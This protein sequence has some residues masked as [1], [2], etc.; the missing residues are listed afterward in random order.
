MAELALKPDRERLMAHITEF[1]RRVKLSGT[2]E[3]LESFRY[4]QAQ[5]DSYGYRTQ[6]LSHD[7]YISLPGAAK[8][9]ID[10]KSLRC[11]THSMSVPTSAAG[12][13]GVLV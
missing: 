5:M 11:I 10:G 12:V 7:A 4:L 8:V 6:L 9:E 13:T 1:A 3:E 2:P